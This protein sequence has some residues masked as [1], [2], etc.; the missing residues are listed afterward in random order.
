[1]P[2]NLDLAVLDGTVLPV[3]Q[4]VLPV[5][6]PGLL[7]GDGIFE[8]VRLYGGRP[9]ALADHMARMERSGR[10]MRIDLDAAAVRADILALAGRVG[11]WDGVVRVLVTRGGRRIG[12]LEELTDIDRP[13]SLATIEYVPPRVLD[14]IK[15]LSYGANMLATRRAAERGADEALLVTPHGRL[16][17]GPTSAFFV[18]L[19]GKTLLTPPLTDRVLDSI[20]RRRLLALVPSAREEVITREDLDGAHEAFLASTTREVQAVRSVDD[21][22]LPAAPGP[23]T[24]AAASA[25]QAG[26]RAELANA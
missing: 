9:F 5:N 13:L 7:R 18:S 23:L 17:E 11:E 10:N 12:L 19:D 1:M 8:V 25:F 14:E 24:S 6:D 22:V 4:A 21:L 20:T 15:S 2:A 3:R 26:V 16:L